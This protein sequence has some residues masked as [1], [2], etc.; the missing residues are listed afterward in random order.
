[1]RKVRC[2]KD[3]G[4]EAC[5]SCIAKSI[6]CTRQFAGTS[7]TKAKRVQQARQTFGR[8]GCT[9][10]A[11]GKPTVMALY[12]PPASSSNGFISQSDMFNRTLSANALQSLLHAYGADVQDSTPV[13]DVSQ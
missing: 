10:A 12:Q 6:Q 11:A 1:M 9:H 4:K 2:I 3:P 13:V 8:A 5:N 7:F